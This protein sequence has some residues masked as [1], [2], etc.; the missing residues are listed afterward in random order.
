MNLDR[1]RNRLRMPLARTPYVYDAL[2][3]IRPS[4][5]VDLVRRD[6]R[7]VIEGFLRSGNTFSVAAFEVANGSDGHIAS[8]LHAAA[9][10]R[11]AVRL[12]RPTVVVIREPRDAVLSYLIRRPTLGPVDGL[13]EWVDFY[14]TTWPLRDRFVIAPFEVVTSEFGRVVRAVNDRFGTTFTPYDATPENDRRAFAIVEQMNREE[15]D[16][17]VVETHVA[18]PSRARDAVKERVARSFDGAAVEGQLAAAT[19]LYGR[20]LQAAPV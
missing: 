12:Q 20:Y 9:H 18:R 15:C 13:R 5:R 1:I 10:V 3:G 7:I 2:V 8:H 11:R 6:S 17:E 19:A 16:G 14:R 4:K